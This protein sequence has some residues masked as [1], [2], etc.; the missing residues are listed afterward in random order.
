MKSDGKFRFGEQCPQRVKFSR[1]R[2]AAARSDPV[3]NEHRSCTARCNSLGFFDRAIDCGEI[4]QRS[5]TKAPF[6]RLGP[7]QNR[8]VV[9]A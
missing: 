7:T 3:L 8:V 2:G 9:L 4:Q 5:W 1:C 6:T